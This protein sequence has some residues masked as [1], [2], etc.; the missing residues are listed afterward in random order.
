[1]SLI[2]QRL[3]ELLW[4]RRTRSKVLVR[5]EFFIFLIASGIHIDKS[6]DIRIMPPSATVR[7]VGAR[8]HERGPGAAG[9]GRRWANRPHRH[10]GHRD[11]Q[12]LR[13]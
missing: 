1:M 5:I 3:M 6:N 2:P 9:S 7:R 8:E 11:W 12:T 10:P 13:Q 4:L